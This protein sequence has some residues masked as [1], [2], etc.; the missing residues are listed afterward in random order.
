LA[1]ASLQGVDGLTF[2]ASGTVRINKATGPTGLDAAARVNWSIATNG[3]NDP[4]NL[5]PAF[6]SSLTDAIALRIDGSVALDAFGAVV[7]TAS[8]SLTQGTQNIGTGNALIG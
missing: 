5:I 8:F 3:T 6:S 1:A 4:A 2:V 7:G